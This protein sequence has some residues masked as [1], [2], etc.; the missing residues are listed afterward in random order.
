M[1]LAGG[2]ALSPLVLQACLAVAPALVAADGGAKPCIDAGFVPAAT[3]GD[4][5][6]LDADTRARLPEG[7]VHVV[8]EQDT[9]DFAKCLRLIDAPFILA[10]GFTGRRLDH[11]LAALST[12]VAHDGAPCVIVGEADV[13]VPVPRTLSMRMP[14]GTRLSIYPLAPMQGMSTGLEWPIAGLTLGPMAQLGTS[15]R[16]CAPEVTLEFAT[17]GALLMVP[18]A[19]LHAVLEGL[20][21]FACSPR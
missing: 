11:T 21:V 20:G 6:S 10:A 7:S 3:I 4:M 14:V 13:I 18:F 2:G 8:S 19:Q 16:T 1:T 12:L 15:N 17:P 5:D 9:T